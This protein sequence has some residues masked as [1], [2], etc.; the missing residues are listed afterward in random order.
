MDLT[1]KRHPDSDGVNPGRKKS[2]AGFE[3]RVVALADYEERKQQWSFQ[4]ASS[5]QPRPGIF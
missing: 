4:T 5:V 1:R 3:A 2:C